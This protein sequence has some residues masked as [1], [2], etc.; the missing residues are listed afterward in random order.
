[1]RARPWG[2]PGAAGLRAHGSRAGGV[3]QGPCRRGGRG[4]DRASRVRW[5]SGV[6][7]VCLCLGQASCSQ[8]AQTPSSCSRGTLGSTCEAATGQA[9]LPRW[10]SCRWALS[11]TG[12]LPTE[13]NEH[14]YVPSLLQNLG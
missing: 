8:L 7:S 14:V 12:S 1:M 13:T 11:P 5:A 9:M 10:A 6:A 2:V 3:G 4:R